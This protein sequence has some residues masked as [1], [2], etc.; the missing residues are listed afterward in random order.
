MN[1]DQ[2]LD[3]KQKSRREIPQTILIERE[4]I[5]LREGGG[6]SIK[7]CLMSGCGIFM[8]LIVVGIILIATVPDYKE[9]ALTFALSVFAKQYE[10]VDLPINTPSYIKPEFVS[11]VDNLKSSSNLVEQLRINEQ[12][13]NSYLTT[14]DFGADITAKTDFQERGVKVFIKSKK[15]SDSPWIKIT[16]DNPANG[17]I[18]L[19]SAQLGPIEISPDGL[20]SSL[21]TFNIGLENFNFERIN[22]Y[23]D[24]LLLP[25]DS[26]FK[27]EKID[28]YSDYALLRLIRK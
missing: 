24:Q 25:N 21:K 7:G 17:Q 4:K 20:R 18:Q 19:K 26:K 2:E 16:L 5:I 14:N 10:P 23:L 11:T 22:E 12:E 27:I 28:V 15:Y 6:F 3:K 13:F 8:A 9:K 1:Q